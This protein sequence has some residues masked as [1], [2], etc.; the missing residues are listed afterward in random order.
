MQINQ[1]DLG[2]I[3]D[4]FT[5]EV[6]LNKRLKTVFDYEGGY[7]VFSSAELPTTNLFEIKQGEIDDDP[8]FRGLEEVRF[9]F[10]LTFNADGRDSHFALTKYVEFGF[11]VHRDHF[12]FC[13]IEFVESEQMIKLRKPQGYTDTVEG[14]YFESLET[15]CLVRKLF[16]QA[17]TQ[18]ESIEKSIRLCLD[19]KES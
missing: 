18:M 15:F 10:D 12:E 16:T 7:V 6:Q 14:L 3:A 5:L 1:D 2:I 19:V 9:V 13:R 17:K 8:E 4:A 11:G